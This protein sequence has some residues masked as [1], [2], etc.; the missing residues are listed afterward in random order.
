MIDA[1]LFRDIMAGVAGPVTIVTT[2]DDGK[3]HGATVSS[4]ASLSLAPPLV[5]VALD[6]RSRLLQSIRNTGKF[7]INILDH[8]QAEL[9]RTFAGPSEDRFAGLRWRLQDGVPALSN[10]AGFMVCELSQSLESG[11][12]ELLIGL[13]GTGRTTPQ[14]PLI[15]SHRT[16]GTNSGR[17]ALVS[18]QFSH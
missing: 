12:H 17:L 2:F 1:Q 8:H 13:V 6:S 4:L 16:F 9:A 3:P 7:G 18:Q 10:A 5:S 15:Y 11:D 14:A